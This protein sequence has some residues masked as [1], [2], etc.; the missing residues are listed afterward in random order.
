MKKTRDAFFHLRDEIAKIEVYSSHEHFC[1]EEDYLARRLDFSALFDYLFL[2][3]SAS[4]L[5]SDQRNLLARGDISEDEKWDIFEPFRACVVN[6]DYF[7]NIRIVLRDLYGIDD[8]TR[9]TYRQVGEVMRREQQLGHYRRIMAESR[10][11]YALVDNCNSPGDV[12]RFD[13]ER[14][15]LVYRIADVWFHKHFYADA[16]INASHKAMTAIDDYVA[17]LVSAGVK[18]VKLAMATG[19]IHLGFRKWD[20][21]D[22]ERSFNMLMRDE[23]VSERDVRPFRDAVVFRFVRNA[24]EH[25]MLVQIHTGVQSY[26]AGQPYLLK[27]MIDEFPDATIDVFHAGYPYHGEVAVLGHLFGNVYPDLC[28]IAFLSKTVAKRILGDWLDMVPVSKILAFGSDFGFIDS[29]YGY[30]KVV[31]ELVA[32]VFEEKILSGRF[33][34]DEAIDMSR[35]ILR[36]NLKGLVSRL[37]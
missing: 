1:S 30:Q 11:E 27:N 29:L 5:P 19:G 14:F 17:R 32:E 35:K 36:E 21:T 20:R 26:A 15:G 16:N 24:T 34:E 7:H 9:E 37:S 4:G 13:P 6:V 31:R 10:V 12:A 33:T 28:W 8:L 23:H 18:G 22:V 25:G 2:A 3:L